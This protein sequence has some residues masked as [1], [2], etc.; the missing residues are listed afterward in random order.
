[1]NQQVILVNYD[2]E[3]TING[4]HSGV[5]KI[6]GCYFTIVDGKLIRAKFPNGK[7]YQ[8]DGKYKV[9]FKKD[10]ASANPFFDRRFDFLKKYYL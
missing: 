8:L 3:T 1:M 4:V 6:D 7:I 5:Q 10:L 2:E 9:N